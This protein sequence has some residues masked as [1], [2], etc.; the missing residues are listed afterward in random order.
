MK[1]DA[2]VGILMLDTRFPRIPGDIGN[3]ATF[4]F[5]VHYEIV[6][7]ASPERVVR[8]RDPALLEPFIAAA[9]KLEAAGV[10]G[11]TTTCGFLALFQDELSAAVSVPVVTSSLMQVALVE[12]MLPNGRRAGILTISAASLTPLHLE[13]AK[14]PLDI[15]IGT[16]DGGRV[17]TRAVL[18]NEPAF[19]VQLAREDNVDAAMAL[20]TRHP[21]VGAIVLEC[22]N[23]PPYAMAIA[24]ATGLPVYS[25]NAGLNAI[26]HGQPL[27]PVIAAPK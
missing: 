27:Q 7:G 15:P 8:Q 20:V 18:G 16:T 22:T 9:R 23:M 11:I 1:H 6:H 2:S 25:L 14:V 5:P 13:K 21:E 17:F 3:P 4:P 24:G 19:D 26:W 10:S 12:Q